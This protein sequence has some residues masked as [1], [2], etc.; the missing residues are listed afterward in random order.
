MQKID[1]LLCYGLRLTLLAKI[2]Y[3]FGTKQHAIL[4]QETTAISK[5][6]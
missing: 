1:E 4:E 5:R 2:F 3:T 6:L